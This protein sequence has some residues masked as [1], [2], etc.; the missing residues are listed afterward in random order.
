VPDVAELE[1]LI[2]EAEK[3]DPRPIRTAPEVHPA[4]RAHREE[5]SALLSGA[6]ALHDADLT[7]LARVGREHDA[8]LRRL[9][10]DARRS[11]IEQ[12]AEAAERLDAVVMSERAALQA[13]REDWRNP[14]V[15]SW[16]PVYFIRSTP[17]ARLGDTHIEDAKSWAK[18][19]CFFHLWQN[20]EE[21]LVLADISVRLNLTGHFEC[22]A[23]GNGVPAGWFWENRGTADVSA[24][25]TIWPLWI[26]HDPLQQP[27]HIVPVADLTVTAGVFSHSADTSINQS[28][29]VR[30][31]RYAVP[32]EAFI[33]IEASVALDHI[34][35]SDLDFA[36]GDFRVGSPY[37]FVTVPA[38]QLNVNP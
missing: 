25:L 10:D 31:A 21:Q 27:Q 1:A 16:P 20:T 30:T 9:A 28:L 8:E 23:E 4:L 33:L 12:S 2:A 19:D 5:A 17:G 35:I 37:C 38:T 6:L 14:W 36:S 22:S 13:L 11:A 15:P 24:R 29:L 34:G 26:A 3:A 32:T 7:E 18:W